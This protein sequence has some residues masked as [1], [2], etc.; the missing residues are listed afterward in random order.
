MNMT[1]VDVTHLPAAAGDEAVLLGRQG[2]EV[3]TAEHLADLLNSIPYEVVTLP[4]YTW[5][6]IPI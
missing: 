4:G 2:H 6:R 5:T 3:I 1:M